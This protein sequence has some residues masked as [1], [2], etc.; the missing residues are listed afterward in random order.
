[1][2]CGVQR[3]VAMKKPNWWN[4]KHEGTWDRVK[5]AMKRDWEQTKHDF[6]GKAPDLD[7]GVGD[8]VKQM[9]GKQPMPPGTLPNESKLDKGWDEI[10]PAFRYGV[11]A[12]AY[13]N[14]DWTKT[15][16]RLS[17]EWSSLEDDREWD[18]V[19]GEVRRAYEYG[20]KK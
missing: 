13:Y 10:E 14:E 20:E 17:N 6:G 2:A 8:T 9:A 1:M 7:Q 18:D 11:G 4:D 12:R 15:E 16:S 19:K 3:H 5:N